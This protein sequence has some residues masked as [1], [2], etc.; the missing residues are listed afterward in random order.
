MKQG[1]YYI[2]TH[3]HA[4]ISHPIRTLF[5]AISHAK[6]LLSCHPVIPC[7]CLVIVL[8]WIVMECNIV[9]KDPF[10]FLTNCG[11]W[12]AKISTANPGE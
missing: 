7:H 5:P 10:W 2:Y 12:Q 4:P 6:V 9:I 11:F 1:I 3:V 8:S